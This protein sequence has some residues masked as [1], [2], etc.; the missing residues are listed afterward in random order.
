[1][2]V[3]GLPEDIRA[4]AWKAQVRLRQ[5]YRTLASIGKALLKVITAI[6]RELVGLIWDI[7]RRIQ[8]A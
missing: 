6:A 8:L 4:I 2:R 1:M 3:E 5:H 7:G